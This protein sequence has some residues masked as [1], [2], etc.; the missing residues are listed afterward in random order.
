MKKRISFLFLLILIVFIILFNN[1]N[2]DNPAFAFIEK[3]DYL[4]K[5]SKTNP[6]YDNYKFNN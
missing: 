3:E 4:E 2:S 6:V 1:K 5:F